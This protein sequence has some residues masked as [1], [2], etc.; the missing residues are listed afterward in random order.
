MVGDENKNALLKN[1]LIIGA[2]KKSTNFVAF[3]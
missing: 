3:K 2:P 1:I